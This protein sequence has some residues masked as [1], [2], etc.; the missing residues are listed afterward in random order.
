MSL[1]LQSMH[2]FADRPVL[3]LENEKCVHAGLEAHEFAHAST[4]DREVIPRRVGPAKG[5]FAP[6]FTSVYFCELV[7]GQE[8]AAGNR[9]GE[10]GGGGG[11]GGETFSQTT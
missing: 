6:R 1:L 9:F 5:H 8:H 7:E 10:G 4:L 3:T 11:G 2:M